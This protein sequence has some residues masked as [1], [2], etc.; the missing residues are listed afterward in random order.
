MSESVYAKTVGL[1]AALN[2]RPSAEPVPLP[3]GTGHWALADN[4]SLGR[5][6]N[7]MQCNAR[8][9]PCSLA[10][11]RRSYHDDARG[12]RVECTYMQH[13]SH[14]HHWH[15]HTYIYIYIHMHICTHTQLRKRS[16]PSCSPKNMNGVG[17]G[18]LTVKGKERSR[19]T[20]TCICAS[21]H[22]PGSKPDLRIYERQSAAIR[23]T[24]RHGLYRRGRE[25][26]HRHRVRTC[27]KAAMRQTCSAHQFG[28]S[29]NRL[30]SA[31]IQSVSQITLSQ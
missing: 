21:A 16:W 24:R 12:S 8:Y 20:I 10:S 26:R 28:T 14:H 30:H 13:P 11:H 29:Q 2:I 19:G 25:D 7:A 1:G 15:T 9:C 18:R 3:V 27:S 31:N 5:G 6:S 23:T 17:P 4:W 22:R